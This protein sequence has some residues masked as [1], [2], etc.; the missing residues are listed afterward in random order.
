MRLIKS[1]F[2]IWEQSSGLEGI[3]KMIEKAGRVCY[4]SEDKITEDSAK[5][6][7]DRMIA[8]GHGAMLEHGTVY[9]DAPNSAGDYNL[10]P[11][12]ASN[13]HSRVVIRFLDGRVHNYV[14]TNFRVIVENFAEV[15][16]PD[17]LQYLCEPTEFH[18]KKITVKFIL[19]RS[20]AQE[21]TRH[22]VFSFAM[23]SQ[24]Y[25]AYNKDKFGNEVTFI[26]PC[27]SSLIEGNY[28][29]EDQN[30]LLT[31]GMSI[32]EAGYDD[33]SNLWIKESDSDYYNEY[34]R[35][36]D[37]WIETETFMHSLQVAEDDYLT[38]I[39]QGWKPQQAREVLPNACKTE[40]V[41][42]GF[43]DDWWGEYLVIDKSTG[44][45]DQRIHGKFYT[46]LNNVDK[47]KYRIVEKGFFPLRCSKGAHPQAQE[48]AIP[49]REEFIK[50]E[51]TNE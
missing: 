5:S 12:F 19:S 29:W 49:L 15:Y 44:L 23:E 11:F 9:L 37:N 35:H 1:Q 22:R 8:S 20:I 21:Y 46:E 40:L 2:E 13:P 31:A 34:K 45:I 6:F 26:I 33:A 10:V 48:L 17:I 43:V 24:R 47:E 32:E 50:K 18:K 36:Y 7:V 14:T 51:Y 4:K 39:N 3:Y 16:I 41:M 42:T 25:C 30:P 27:W 28:K 38:L